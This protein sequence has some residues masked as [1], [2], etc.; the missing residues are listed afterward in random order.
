MNLSVQ[1]LQT[2][3]SMVSNDISVILNLACIK[4]TGHP[5][6]DDGEYPTQWVF[7]TNNINLVPEM[8]GKRY[9]FL[10][11][12]YKPTLEYLP[13]LYRPSTL[14]DFGHQVKRRL[15]VSE[16]QERFG[17]KSRINLDLTIVYELIQYYETYSRNINRAVG[18]VRAEEQDPQRNTELPWHKQM[19][20]MILCGEQFDDYHQCEDGYYSVAGCLNLD[21]RDLQWKM[22]NYWSHVRP[23]IMYVLWDIESQFYLPRDDK[24]GMYIRRIKKIDKKIM[25]FSKELKNPTY[26]IKRK[27]HKA[28]RDNIEGR[29]WGKTSYSLAETLLERCPMV[30]GSPYYSTQ[31]GQLKKN[32][33]IQKEF[34]DAYNKI[35]AILPDV[36]A[37]YTHRRMYRIDNIKK[38][39]IPTIQNVKS[40]LQRDVVTT[41]MKEGDLDQDTVLRVFTGKRKS[42]EEV[43]MNLDLESS[44]AKARR[45]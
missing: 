26:P 30:S 9:G 31:C 17:M 29:M 22:D 39:F 20:R 2:S 4:A 32:K 13:P 14:N 5:L 21:N 33:K 11:N 1:C 8:I 15:V 6:P 40:R 16:I 34:I 18:V 42:S 10:R 37:R 3:K 27:I 41:W 12:Q 36:Q 44:Y 7:R 38:S 24:L 28:M 45:S 35:N 23:K 25:E 43:I 19:I